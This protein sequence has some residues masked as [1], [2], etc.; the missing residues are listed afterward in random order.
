[1]LAAAVDQ[2]HPHAY[3]PQGSHILER[4]IQLGLG[5]DG[6][7]AVFDHHGLALGPL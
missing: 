7:A 5:P 1:M 6:G 2:H 4:G 3:H